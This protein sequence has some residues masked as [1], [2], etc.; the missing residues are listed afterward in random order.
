M[1]EQKTARSISLSAIA[2]TVAAFGAMYLIM[3]YFS[4]DFWYMEPL[5]SFIEGETST[6]DFGAIYDSISYHYLNDNARLSNTVFTFLIC[7]PRQILALI[8]TLLTGAALVA[9]MRLA[10][11]SLRRWQAV[12]WLCALFATTLPWYDCMF[13]LCFQFNY[14]WGLA[15]MLAALVLFL[16]DRARSCRAMLPAFLLGVIIGGWH[17]GFSV[18][19]LCACMALAI[20]WPRRYLSASRIA[21][22]AGLCVGILWLVTA[23]PFF[24]YTEGPD[25]GQ[26]DIYSRIYRT[27]RVNIFGVGGLALA[28]AALWRKRTRAA[29]LAP[30]N[31]ACAAGCTAAMMIYGYALVSY[32]V[33][34]PAQLL[35][36]PLIVYNF[37]LLFGG[38]HRRWRMV[39]GRACTVLAGVFL[40]VHY[41]YSV[42]ATADF[43]AGMKRAEG[44]D[45]FIDFP[46]TAKTPFAALGK[47]IGLSLDT[48]MQV[49]ANFRKMTARPALHLLPSELEYVTAESGRP[50]DGTPG[51][52]ELSGFYFIPVEN[53]ELRP[54][55]APNVRVCFGRRYHTVRS[56]TAMPFTS[57]GDGKDYYCIFIN[58]MYPIGRFLPITSMEWN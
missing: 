37:S 50:V 44:N 5:R 3:P 38:A 12:V 23:P 16:S 39:S 31:V 36:I 30:A 52:R 22:M 20:L 54:D 8:S 15:C 25:V 49:D 27:L 7:I 19:A 45:A 29:A 14:V 46:W 17:E 33:A 51:L 53:P 28:L 40:T 9:L 26:P 42:K 24:R 41:A 2:L 58:E 32:R 6:P 48:Y 47:P 56:F 35:A 1:T 10:R 18:P 4:D 34:F 43:R 13:S 55:V 21:L 57:R 11:V